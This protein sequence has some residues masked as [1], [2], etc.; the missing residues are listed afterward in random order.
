MVGLWG[1]LGIGP[2]AI[3]TIRRVYPDLG[4]LADERPLK[5]VSSVGLAAPARE[6]L[7]GLESTLGAHAERLLERAL[8]GGMSVCF[9]EDPVYPRG[10]AQVEAAPP[11][12]FYLGRGDRPNGPPRLAMVGSRSFESNFIPAARA[13]ALELAS[14]LIIVSGGAR[15]IDQLC[16]D[17]AIE[18]GGETWA[19]MGSGLDAL[20]SPQAKL[21]PRIVGSGGTVFSDFPPGVRADPT[22]FPRRNRLIS[23]ASDG[24]LLVRGHGES[25][26][27]IT[28]EYAQEQ[29]RL[30]MAVPGQIDHLTAHAPNQLIRAG[31]ARLVARAADVF[32]DMGLTQTQTLPAEVGAEAFDLTKLSPNAAHAYQLLERVPVDFDSLLGRAQPLDSGL[33]ASAL[34]E[35]ELAGLLVQRAGRR[36][37]R[38]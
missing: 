13:L 33:L 6:G 1:V 29:G 38:R 35:L 10:L 12:L 23:G 24:V 32:E 16:H 3:A 28:V 25:G 8:D 36:Y 9:P 31:A 4:V 22:T 5:W 7:L 14:R 2:A 37:E 27:L 26:A 17:A 15:G 34:I 21:A 30:V 19:F 11:M 20:D 18:A